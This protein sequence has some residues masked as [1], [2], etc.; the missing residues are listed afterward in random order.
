MIERLKN[1]L[2]SIK[3]IH[4]STEEAIVFLFHGLYS[5]YLGCLFISKENFVLLIKEAENGW[6]SELQYF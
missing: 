5:L 1:A 3:I 2:F 6:E 4:L